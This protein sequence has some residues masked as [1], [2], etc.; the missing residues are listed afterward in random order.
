MDQSSL[1]SPSH[2]SFS[3]VGQKT[4]QYEIAA[5]FHQK[6]KEREQR[7]KQKAGGISVLVYEEPPGELRNGG[8]RHDNDHA[9]IQQIRTVPTEQEV[10]CEI[11]PYLPQNKAGT[12]AHLEQ[13]SVNAHRDLHFRLLRH[14]LVAD[15]HTAITSFVECGGVKGFN[16]VVSRIH[17][18]LWIFSGFR[19]VV[20]VKM[21]L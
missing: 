12:V 17:L 14:N 16:K 20:P 8:P 10:L 3:S 15:L 21:L 7:R 13:G 6:L 1:S 18:V 5:R 4:G 9:D 2:I 19:N 11:P